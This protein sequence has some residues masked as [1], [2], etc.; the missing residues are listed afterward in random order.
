MIGHPSASYEQ[1]VAAIERVSREY[2]EA[3]VD[4]KPNLL[5]QYQALLEK[6]EQ[7]FGLQS[8]PAEPE[9]IPK[10]KKRKNRLS[11]EARAKMS[12]RMRKWQAEKK[13]KSE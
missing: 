2:R 4:I 11:P 3:D 13:A 7:Y 8:A 10:K 6:E 5:F 9:E 1:L 12:E